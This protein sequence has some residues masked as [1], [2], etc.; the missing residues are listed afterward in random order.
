MLPAADPIILCLRVCLRLSLAL[1]TDPRRGWCRQLILHLHLVCFGVAWSRVQSDYDAILKLL[2]LLRLLILLVYWCHS[3]HHGFAMWNHS[4][5][6]I[7]RFIPH[8]STSQTT[9]RKLFVTIGITS[10]QGI[11]VWRLRKQTFYTHCKPYCFGGVNFVH[12]I[13]SSSHRFVNAFSFPALVSTL[14]RGYMWNKI[15]SKLF[16]PSS[17]S[18]WNDF[19]WNY[20]KIIS[21]AYCSSWIF[22]NMFNVA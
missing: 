7:S 17:T 12:F 1:H 9:K 20:F 4:W 19:A 14:W 6:E 2:L 11:L 5:L 18:A 22:S 10:S 21:E 8:K 13:R 16:Q 15:I 3:P